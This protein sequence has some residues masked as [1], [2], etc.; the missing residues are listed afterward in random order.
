MIK[1]C[2]VTNLEKSK[3]RNPWFVEPTTIIVL[4]DGGAMTSAAG[5]VQQQLVLPVSQ[6]PDAAFT[7]EPFRYEILLLVHLCFDEF[8]FK[9]ISF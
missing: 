6:R 5:G 9:S 7:L 1:L 8:F 3:G 2:F 4:T